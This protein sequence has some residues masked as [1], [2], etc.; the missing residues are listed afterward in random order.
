M[1]LKPLNVVDGLSVGETPIDVIDANGNVTATNLTVTGISDLGAIG[2][3]TITGGSNGQAIVTDGTGNLSFVTIEGGGNSAAPMPYFIPSTDTL[4]VP[5]NFQ[6]LFYEP[7]DIEGTFEVDGIL[8]DVSGGGTG[9]GIPGGNSTQVQFNDGGVFGGNAGLTFTKANT[10]LTANN[11]IATSSANLGDVSNLTIS[12]GNANFVLQ[13][14]GFGNLSWVEQTGGGGT[15][16]VTVDDF[17]GNGVQTQFTLSVTPTDIDYTSV[18]YNGVLLLRTDYSVAGNVLTTSSPPANGSSLEVTIL[19]SSGGGGGGGTPGGANTQ[20]QFNNDGAFAGNV[21]FT[22]DLTTG[23]LVAPVFQGEGANIANIP[24]GNVTGQVNFA[25]TANSVAGAN[26]T[27][28]VPLSTL[29]NSAVSVSGSN[30]VGAV[31]YAVVANAV[32]GSNVTGEVNFAA[33]ANSVAGANVSGAVSYATTANSVAGANVSG[34]VSYAAIANSVAGANV[35]GAVSYATTANSVAGS[36][37]TGAVA[38]ATTANSVAGANVTGEVGLATYATTANSV[39]GANVSGSVASATTAGTVTTAAQP[40]IT[41]VGT[42]SSVS[43]TGNVTS[44]NIESSGTASVGY[45]SVTSS[46]ASITGSVN[47]TGDIGVTGN[48]NVTGN[49][50][51]QN[52]TDLVVGDPLIYLAANSVGDTEDIGLVGNYNDGGYAHTGLARD[53]TDNTWK[54]FTGVVNEPTT[55]ID[56][57]NASYPSVKTGNL[58]SANITGTGWANITGNITAGNADLGNSVTANYFIGSGAN[59][60]SIPGANVS[61]EVGL[62]TYATTANSVAA[63]NISGTVNLANFATTANSVAGSNVSG[64]VSNSLIAGTVYTAAQPNITS[65]GTLTSLSVTANITA[66][67][68]Y[69]NSGTVGASLLTGALTTASQPNITSVGTLSSLTVTANVTAGNIYANSGT[70]GAGTLSGTLATASQPNITSVGTLT[71]LEVSGNINGANAALGNAAVANYL[72]GT[73]ITAAQPNITSVGTLTSLGIGTAPQS[74]T[75]LDVS[76]SVAGFYAARIFNTSGTGYGLKIKNGSDTNDALRISNAADSADNILMYGSGKA[77]F[78]DNVGVGTTSPSGLWSGDEKVLQV[79]GTGSTAAGVK[80]STANA[81]AELFSSGASTEWGLYSNSSSSFTVYTAGTQQLTV[82]TSGRL[83]VRT[84]SPTSG[85]FNPTIAAKSIAD[86]IGGGIMVEGSGADAT[87]SMGYDGT[88]MFLSSSYRS[89]AGYKPIAFYTSGTQQLTLST[90]GDLAL[91]TTTTLTGGASARWFTLNGSGASYSGGIIYAL[92]GAAKGYT[93][94]QSGFMCHQAVSGYGHTFYVNNSSVGAMIDSS[95]R[96]LLGGYTSSVG[97]YTLQV[98]GNIY[99]SGTLT[100]ASSIKLKE[101]IKPITNAL[102]V[103]C[104]LEG[105]TYDKKDGSSY[106]EPGFIAERVAEVI[107]SLVD[108][109]EEG[110]PIGVKYN[111]TIAYL[112][113]AVKELKAEIDLLKGSK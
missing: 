30:I 104:K 39:A 82:D 12:G 56:W 46:G 73:L 23:T 49:L 31:P 17:T 72:G 71:S 75:K 52:V 77:T 7:I 3:I 21:G 70:I 38:Y 92:E 85:G 47:I 100:E 74:G 62:A 67:N 87:L 98:S 101:N 103:V 2:N 50:N 68:V 64:Q 84:S 96:T 60:T 63:A 6:G 105:V 1:A 37:V 10:T 113:E 95:G 14:D 4:T 80:V 109:D 53:H 48:F 54:F 69:A 91:G 9:N 42:L 57:A 32:S 18:N 79:S 35:S 94:Y 22:Y 25:A 106:N 27:G 29:A 33:T 59:L 34:E 16:S 26:V 99:L 41:S 66:G 61:G 76:G 81:S 110:N 108:R 43:V 65:V 19:S 8:I 24:G 83:S 112:V 89:T 15:V 13:T 5:T 102:D 90:G 88:A 36:N 78:A 86:S 20:V 58:F 93:Y 107:E 111:K 40:N 97:S 55:V 28:Y 51:Y 44:G 45:L 11:F